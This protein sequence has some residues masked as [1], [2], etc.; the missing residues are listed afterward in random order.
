[1]VRFPPPSSSDAAPPTIPFSIDEILQDDRR[2]DDT[3]RTSSPSRGPNYQDISDDEE[4]EAGNLPADLSRSHHLH[5]SH[6][7][8]PAH[9]NQP[10]PF[11]LSSQ[12]RFYQQQQHPQHARESFISASA[13]DL[14]RQTQHMSAEPHMQF[15]P[16]DSA[17]AAAA[18]AAASSMILGANAPFDAHHSLS[19]THR[20]S[21]MGCGRDR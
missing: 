10:R 13:V 2:P 6:D 8:F 16:S 11:D 18:A 4:T 17:S 14:G 9:L 21:T 1:M 5:H 3:A 15:H 12:F 7:S 20:Q 19:L